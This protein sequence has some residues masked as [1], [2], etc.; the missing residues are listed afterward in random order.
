MKKKKAL[1]YLA[2]GPWLITLCMILRS[3]DVFFRDSILKVLRPLEL[4]TIEHLIGS[5]VLLPAIPSF[6]FLKNL[7]PK[8]W[9][10]IVFIACGSSVGG[11]LFFTMAFQYVNPAVVILLQKLQPLITISLSILILK[12]RVDKNLFTLGPIA[13]ISGYLLSFGLKSPLEIISDSN[14]LGI[15]YSI[16]AA[17]LWGGGAVFGKSLLNKIE[18][19]NV[20]R[21]RYFFGLIFCLILSIFFPGS[22]ATQIIDQPQY[23][24][25]ICYMA[26][27]PGLLSLW[28]YYKG[29]KSTSASKTSILELT[30]PLASVI[31]VWVFLG[32]PLSTLQ[33]VSGSVMLGSITMLSLQSKKQERLESK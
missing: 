14:F 9:F 17:F 11:I 19:I 33:I 16:F 24:A 29:L 31:I 4:I 5:L 18:S 21:L 3:T 15:L 32:R 10:S 26:I 28:L 22:N 6:G 13:I 8:N 12:E 27:V 30:F 1:H 23:L 25:A 2:I 20:T 7:S